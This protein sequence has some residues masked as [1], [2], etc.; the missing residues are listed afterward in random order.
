MGTAREYQIK[1]KYADDVD[2]ELKRKIEQAVSLFKLEDL[3][4]KHSDYVRDILRTAYIYNDDYFEGLVAQYSDLFHSKQEAQDFVF[5]NYLDEADWGKRVLAKLTHDIL[6]L[7]TYIPII[8]H[9]RTCAA[10]LGLLRT[11]DM[12]F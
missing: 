12:Q 3:Y 6:L 9:K 4:S 8:F 7:Y 11:D 5:F 1:I 10:G 2:P